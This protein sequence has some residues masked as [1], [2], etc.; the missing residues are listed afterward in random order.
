MKINWFILSLLALLSYSFMS[1]LIVFLIRK[2]FPASFVLLGLSIVLVIFFAYQTFAVSHYK[3]SVNLWVV[4]ALILIGILS[5]VANLWAYQAASDAPN[6]GLALAITGMQA[7]GV[8]MLAFIFFRDKLTVVQIIGVVF[9][10]VAI[11]LISIGSNQNKSKEL[12]N[13]TSYHKSLK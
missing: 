9:S 7:V 2:G 4:L 1:F 11:F 8:S 3:V 12:P 5:A 6:P 10:I 13:N